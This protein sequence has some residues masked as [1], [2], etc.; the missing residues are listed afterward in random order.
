MNLPFV[1]VN[2][3]NINSVEMN[4]LK[5]MKLES[6]ISVESFFKTLG[7]VL[8]NFKVG[9]TTKVLTE[10]T[11]VE[12]MSIV[13]Q[14]DKYD[15][16]IKNRLFLTLFQELKNIQRSRHSAEI[17]LVSGIKFNAYFLKF[18]KLS[19]TVFIG[20][21]FDEADLSESLFRHC[22][23]RGCSF[24]ETDLTKVNFIKSKFIGCDFSGAIL[25]KITGFNNE[26][27]SNIYK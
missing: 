6:D 15:F 11:L 5:N 16:S 14:N 21:I 3:N 2:K 9:N 12:M 7:Y 20:C 1:K 19:N 4:F 8:K 27:S 18:L 24:I 10:Q 26:N 13:N 25:E 22:E 23:F 17:L